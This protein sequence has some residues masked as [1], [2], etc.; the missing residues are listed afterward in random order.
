MRK[1]DDRLINEVLDEPDEVKKRRIR[2][3]ARVDQ[4]C[5]YYEIDNRA[6]NRLTNSGNSWQ[7]Q[8]LTMQTFE[9]ERSKHS[10]TSDTND[11]NRSSKHAAILMKWIADREMVAQLLAEK[12]QSE[13]T[14]NNQRRSSSTVKW[15]AQGGYGNENRPEE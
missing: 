3:D 5:R 6:R 11:G 14:G 13:S 9:P 4:F 15:N 10:S 12:S 8:L 7:M 2:I 1:I